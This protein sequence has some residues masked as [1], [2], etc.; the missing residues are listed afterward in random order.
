MQNGEIQ[1]E[2]SYVQ[3][4]LSQGGV[5]YG[6]FS[7]MWRGQAWF[8]IR[9]DQEAHGNQVRQLAQLRFGALRWA[10]GKPDALWELL[11]LIELCGPWAW[12][13]LQQGSDSTPVMFAGALTRQILTEYWRR[14]VPPPCADVD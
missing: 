6:I 2:T 1:Y 10:S 12:Q 7:G 5:I 4:P 9:P 13:V 8:I 11:A 3:Y 14:R